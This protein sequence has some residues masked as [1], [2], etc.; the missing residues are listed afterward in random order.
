MESQKTPVISVILPVFNEEALLREHVVE[1]IT[2]V[3]TLQ[4]E[5]AFEILLVN[6]GSS[7]RSG[8]IAS[9]L[10]AEFDELR[11][12]T[13]PTNFGA[14]QAFKFGFA[15]TRGDYVVT[16]DVDL[17]YD[18]HHIEEL[19]T[20]LRMEHA[21]IVLASPYMN[22]GTISN[23]P[24]MRKT[25]SI[26]GNR[27]LSLVARGNFS[28]LTSMVRAYDGPFIRAL[29]LRSMGMDILPE[30]LYKSM[31][32]R[33]KIVETPGRLDWERQLQVA[34]QRFSSMKILKH[35][36]STISSGFVFRPM[37]FF[38]FPGILI[39]LF[40]LYVNFWMF[41][42]FFGA[43]AEL[44]GAGG[45]TFAKAF[46]LAY[47]KYPHTFVTGLLSAMLTIQLLGLGI[48]TAQNKR[49]FE[50]LF[51]LNSTELKQLKVKIDD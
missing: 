43:V 14:G 23:V 36:Y 29:D 38:I 41:T 20:V 3:R 51:H 17:S 49:Y 10:A 47:S 6:D 33:A 46:A 2:H 31:V 4:D 24:F 28:T 40:S 30:M 7:D 13:H 15:N 22:G 34:G 45:A 19:V 1:I 12:L 50:E 39:G 11:V 5:Y 25:L 32:V 27:F 21:K 9:E 48:I 37:L 8:E 26:W 42:H 44:S 18:V 16:M 35:V